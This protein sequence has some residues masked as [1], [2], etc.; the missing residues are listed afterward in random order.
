M[1]KRAAAKLSGISVNNCVQAAAILTKWLDLASGP[2]SAR[3]SV[4]AGGRPSGILALNLPGKLPYLQNVRCQVRENPG[5]RNLD[6]EL[7]R[8]VHGTYIYIAFIYTI[9]N[10]LHDEI[11]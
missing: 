8:I 4:S 1:K 6:W 2:H 10:S 5:S 11:I 9:S 7:N 3:T